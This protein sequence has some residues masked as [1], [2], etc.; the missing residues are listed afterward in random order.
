MSHLPNEVAAAKFLHLQTRT[1]SPWH[2]GSEGPVFY[3][4]DG[5]IRYR[6]DDLENFITRGSVAK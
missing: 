1:L 2:S 4:I 6:P 3:K 5:A